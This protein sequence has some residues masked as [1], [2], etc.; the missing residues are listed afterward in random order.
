MQRKLVEPE[1][2]RMLKV[3][4]QKDIHFDCFL[5][6]TK[7]GLPCIRQFWGG[8][9]DREILE[10]LHP[11]HRRLLQKRSTVHKNIHSIAYHVIILS[12]Y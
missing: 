11:K 12:C 9:G 2:K 8:N 4:L 3:N 1:G 7:G 6:V 5:Y 10:A